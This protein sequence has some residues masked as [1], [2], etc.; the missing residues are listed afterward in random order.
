MFNI[1]NHRASG[2]IGP[3]SLQKTCTK[4]QFS[5]SVHQHII[6]GND[7]EEDGPANAWGISDSQQHS[8]AASRVIEEIIGAVSMFANL[9]FLTIIPELSV[10]IISPPRY[11]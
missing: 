5:R 8:H 6:P 10:S 2:I 4:G 7:G 9:I 3:D 1:N 11:S